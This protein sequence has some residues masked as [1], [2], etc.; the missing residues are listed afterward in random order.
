MSERIVDAGRTVGRGR[1]YVLSCVVKYHIEDFILV[2][3][4]HAHTLARSRIPDLAG[5]V[6]AARDDHGAVPIELSTA[7][8][9]FVAYQRMDTSFR[10]KLF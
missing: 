10:R 3:D 8:L 6:H 1:G 5:F 2:T 7:Y 4:E 9:G